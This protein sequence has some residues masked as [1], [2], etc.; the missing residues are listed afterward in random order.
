MRA[1]AALAALA[2]LAEPLSAQ[3]RTGPFLRANADLS[4]VHLSKSD[5]LFMGPG[6]SVGGGYGFTDRWSVVGAIGFTNMV[7]ESAQIRLNFFGGNF[8]ARYVDAGARYAFKRTA[9]FEFFSDATVGWREFHF[10]EGRNVCTPSPCQRVIDV[11]DHR[12]I[13]GNITLGFASYSSSRWRVHWA[14]R[15]GFTRYFD[16]ESTE[17]FL[18]QPTNALVTTLELGARLFL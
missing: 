15:R 17:A 16:N 12:G 6:A 10:E 4:V 5:R 8:H 2:I 1:R 9:R 7:S 14:G 13:G 11:T 18:R 3:S